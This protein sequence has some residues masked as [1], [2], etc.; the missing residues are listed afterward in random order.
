MLQSRKVYKNGYVALD[1]SKN[2]TSF[3]SLLWTFNYHTFLHMKNFGWH[4]HGG[5]EE[6]QSS[7]GELAYSRRGFVA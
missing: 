6:P 1:T 7:V 5:E 3:K 2:E 4:K